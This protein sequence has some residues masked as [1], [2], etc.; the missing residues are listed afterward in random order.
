MSCSKQTSNVPFRIRS[1]YGGN[2]PRAT[3]W[4]RGEIATGVWKAE[5]MNNA[6]MLHA[7]IQDRSL[8]CLEITHEK[9]RR[10]IRRTVWYRRRRRGNMTHVVY[11]LTALRGLCQQRCTLRVFVS[12]NV[13]VRQ[14]IIPTLMRKDAETI[15][16]QS[17]EGTQTQP[18]ELGGKAGA[19]PA[20]HW[21]DPTTLK[22]QKKNPSLFTDLITYEFKS[23]TAQTV[24]NW[25]RG[26]ENITQVN[27][28]LSSPG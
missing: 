8:R 21:R 2:G 16:H 23:F 15:T 13:T 12:L 19:A 11:G 1:T 17:R 9:A 10:R 25:G 4:W 20:L 5:T 27:L 6:G 3:K 26:S 22:K 24:S 14:E 28:V 7:F 18:A